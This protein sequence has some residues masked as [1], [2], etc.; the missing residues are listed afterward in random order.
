MQQHLSVA[1]TTGTTG[2]GGKEKTQVMALAFCMV[3][4]VR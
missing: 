4:E 2:G 3:F 1:R